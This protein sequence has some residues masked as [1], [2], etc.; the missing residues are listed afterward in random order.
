MSVALKN[1]LSRLMSPIALAVLMAV[2]LG[3][4][5]LLGEKRSA[6]DE[7]PPFEAQLEERLHQVETRWS[8]AQPL[9]REQ[10]LQGQL[11]PWQQVQVMAQVSGRVEKL[12]RQ[13]GDQVSAGDVLLEL[14]DEGRSMQLAQAR[15]DYRLRQTELQSTRKLRASNY[16]TETEIVRLEGELARAAAELKSAELA[17]QYN[18]PVA[19]FDGVVDRRY[20]DVGELVQSGA[21]LM[22]LVN[23]KR[24][25]ATAQIPQQDASRVAVGQ[26]VK[27]QVTGG[28]E[29][30]GL[31]RFVS[32]AADPATRSFY[33]EIEAD[34]PEL[35]RVAG[36]SATLRIQLPPV[37][38]HQFSPA[39]LRLGPD[40]QLGVHAV[41]EN[42]RV[43]NHPVRVVA[44]TN[45]GATVE[46]LPEKLQVITQGAG[47]VKPG[48]QVEAKVVQTSDAT[49]LTPQPGMGAA[50]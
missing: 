48:Q 26:Q 10:V 49:A 44:I 4:W 7:A 36:G 2:V 15:A 45:D 9:A 37:L 1:K 33:V 3:L 28:R 14:S 42:G 41:D 20:V 29:L 24:L 19:P 18:Q 47:F 6:Q 38:A 39:L 12:S 16:A 40:G 34:N 21:E 31:V 11:Q 30:E 22:S 5:L 43:I 8:Q 13:Q 25:K 27:V 32:L 46:G 35:W 50:E 17:V 23:V